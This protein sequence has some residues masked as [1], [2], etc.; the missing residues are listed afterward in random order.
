MVVLA[1]REQD[2]NYGANSATCVL[3]VSGRISQ[4]VTTPHY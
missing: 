1:V 3:L 2:A 4:R